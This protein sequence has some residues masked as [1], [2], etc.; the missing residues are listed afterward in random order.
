MAVA[1][2]AGGSFIRSAAMDNARRKAIAE[3]GMDRT[4]I[5]IDVGGSSVK[6]AAVAAGR[7]VWS[8]KS[9]R[10]VRADRAA[11]VRA[12]GQVLAGAPPAGRWGLCVPGLLDRATRRITLA[13][14]VP[15]LTG[16]Q[17]DELLADAVGGRYGGGAA[18]TNDAT[19]CG[20]DVCASGRRGRTLVIVLGTGIGATVLDDGEP[21]LV[22]GDTPGHFGQIDVSLDGAAPV[23]WDGSVG[24]LEAYLGAAALAARYGA[25]FWAKLPA[26][27]IDEPP[28]TAL[29]RAIRIGHAIYRPHEVV[30]CGGI[31]K[32]LGALA[33]RIRAAVDAGL[34]SIARPGWTLEVGQSDYHAAAGAARL[35]L[36][37]G[38]DGS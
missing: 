37:M 2:G 19:A 10:Y 21:L 12:I 38:P 25:E 22:D 9:D 16:T 35:A 17:L 36:R 23:L 8:N 15:G 32:Q 20:I 24:T 5:G 33:E 14:N 28:L 6:A 1:R 7:I 18:I 11:L 29:V 13:L 31:G 3:Q 27:R 4:A 34:T 30:L 26:L